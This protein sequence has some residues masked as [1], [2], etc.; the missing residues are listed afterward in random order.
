MEGGNLSYKDADSADA[1]VSR[2]NVMMD[3]QSEL[4]MNFHGSTKFLVT[5]VNKD[6]T[7]CYRESVEIL[8]LDEKA[9]DVISLTMFVSDTFRNKVKTDVLR[10]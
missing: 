4:Y 8:S 2:K 1:F 10:C 6:G 7:D 3:K 9:S 5:L